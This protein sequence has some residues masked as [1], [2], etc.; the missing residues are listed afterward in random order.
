MGTI[1]G[2]SYHSKQIKYN[3]TAKKRTKKD[4]KAIVVHYTANYSRKADGKAHF[5]YFNGADRDSSADVFIDDHSIWKINDWTKYFTW[6]IGDGKGKYGYTNSNTISIEMCVN[7][8]GNFAKT[9]ENTIKYIR[10]LHQNGYTKV[11]I[12]HY[13]A[14]RKLCPIMF[15]DLNISGYNKAYTDFRNKVFKKEVKPVAKDIFDYASL[16]WLHE[17]GF[18]K[19]TDY[20]SSKQFNCEQIAII[21]KRLYEDLKPNNEVPQKENIYTN[22][23]LQWLYDIGF[24][25]G[26]KYMTSKELSYFNCEQ[27]A[28]ILQRLYTNIKG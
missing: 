15:V 27:I 26:K 18:I 22:K 16:K 7:S 23:N 21:L 24:I 1:N 19:G 5:E 4:I 2:I 6:A 20:N 9:V 8:D 25:K 10:Y 14:S 12:R 3:R 28:T 13:D 17:K 11:L